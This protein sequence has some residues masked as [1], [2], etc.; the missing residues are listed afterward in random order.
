MSA[1]EAV[2]R[3][4]EELGVFQPARDEAGVLRN[5]TWHCILVFDAEYQ[6]H[7]R[8]P[9]SFPVLPTNDG[10]LAE[11]KLAAHVKALAE[12]IA[13]VSSAAAKRIRL[14]SDYLMA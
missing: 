8:Y 12:A 4:W 5:L 6:L 9:E 7:R 2:E 3:G 13:L 14:K 1:P 11:P 10:R